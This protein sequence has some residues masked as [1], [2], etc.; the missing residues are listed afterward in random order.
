M[1]SM[2]PR[3]SKLITLVVTCLGTFMVLLDTTII[4][5]ALPTIQSSLHTN[6]SDPAVGR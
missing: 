5:T 4:V 2:T 3:A 1:M 6:L